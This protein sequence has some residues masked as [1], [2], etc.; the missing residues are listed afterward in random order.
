MSSV[1][2][3]NRLPIAINS[4]V[5]ALALCL[6]SSLAWGLNKEDFAL[7]IPIRSLDSNQGNKALLT[8]DIPLDVYRA[9]RRSALADLRVVNAAAEAL[10]YALSKPLAV[11]ELG[12]EKVVPLLAFYVDQSNPGAGVGEVF[13]SKKGDA[14]SLVISPAAAKQSSGRVLSAYYADLKGDGSS[15]SMKSP[16]ALMLKLAAMG[17]S[18]PDVSANVTVETS[19]DLKTWRILQRSAPVFRLSRGTQV[20]SNL[21]ID[22]AAQAIDRYLR[23]SSSTGLEKLPMTELGLQMAGSLKQPVAHLVEL[24]G[25]AAP[26]PAKNTFLFDAGAALPMTRFNLK[27]ADLNTIAP[28]RLSARRL[29]TDPWEL[30]KSETLYRMALGVGVGASEGKNADLLLSG[31]AKEYRYWQVQ[32]DER[33]GE[34]GSRIPALQLSFVPASIVFTARGE[35]PFLLLVGNAQIESQALDMA[36]LVPNDASGRAME[37]SRVSLE[38][39]RASRRGGLGEKVIDTSADDRKKWILWSS[40]IVGVGGLGVF[41][42]RLLKEKKTV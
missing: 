4:R 18:V 38:L 8:A 24:V 41:A 15:G 3:I 22:V 35:A 29:P 9:A 42:A 13:L 23:L 14:V 16:Q 30:L 31:A 34:F 7:E 2:S 28:V 1:Q 5:I 40:L 12:V 20:L 32:I 6:C 39:G 21:T 19:D 11:Q 10:P 26:S 36:A 33:A 25:V 17:E 27:F 37:L